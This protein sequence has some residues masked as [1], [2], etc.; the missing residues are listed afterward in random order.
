MIKYLEG[1]K[2]DLDSVIPHK[3][4]DSRKLMEIS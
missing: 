1:I 2:S 3:K 4:E